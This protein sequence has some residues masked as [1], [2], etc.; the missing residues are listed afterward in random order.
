ME[1]KIISYKPEHFPGYVLEINESLRFYSQPS[2]NSIWPCAFHIP[3]IKSVHFLTFFSFNLLTQPC[4]PSFLHFG[5][6]VTAGRLQVMYVSKINMPVRRWNSYRS[7][8]MQHLCLT[9]YNPST[10]NRRTAP[11]CW[12]FSL[13]AAP[14]LL[15]PTPTSHSQTA[16]RAVSN[17]CSQPLKTHGSNNWV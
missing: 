13:F 15:F 8:V 7:S 17:L 3:G 12:I 2:H 9:F 5:L 14:V 16:P 6:P 1:R 4:H 10:I 11:A